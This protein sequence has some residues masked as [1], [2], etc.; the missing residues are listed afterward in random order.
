MVSRTVMIGIVA[1]IVVIIAGAGIYVLMQ[2]PVTPPV[3][4]HKM[5]VL[6][7]G[8][9]TDAGWNSAMYVGASALGLEMNATLDVTIAEG[10]GQVG[11]APTMRDY[12]SR[13]Y[14]I[15]VCWT[16]QYTADA[17][18]VHQ[19]YNNT[20]F[21][22]STAYQTAYNVISLNVNL[23]EG[24]F[25]AGLAMGKLTN[26]N[27]IGGVAGYNYATTAA[28]PNGFYDGVKYVNPQVTVLPTIYAGVWDDVGKGRES[29]EALIAQGAD[30]LISRG[31]GLT[32]G[33]IQAASAHFGAQDTVYMVGDMADQHALASKTI[34]TSNMVFTQNQL[35][36]V[37]E[38]I[39]NGTM[40]A[41]S[42]A[43]Q[44]VFTWGVREGVAGIA[45][46]WGLT[47]KIPLESVLLVQRAIDALKAGTFQVIVNMTD[48]TLDYVGTF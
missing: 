36:L 42:D 34:V 47:Y 23:Y 12:A 41:K 16:I 9:I 20:W 15:L 28:V 3:T 43:G 18:A 26:S 14:D 1:A 40:K 44:R 30:L 35:R 45:P 6:L 13:G 27:I 31:D 5:A 19:D 7:P 39:D 21:I 11:V 32:L 22:V 24:A 29:G 33:V 38:M 4:K 25:L 46:Y 8:S 48:G 17:M 2:P 37:V 10:L